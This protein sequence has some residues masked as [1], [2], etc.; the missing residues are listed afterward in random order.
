MP[1]LRVVLLLAAAACIGGLTPL[2]VPACQPLPA[3]LDADAIALSSQFFARSVLHYGTLRSGVA[4][5]VLRGEPLSFLTIGGSVAC[6]NS[7]GR[8]EDTPRGKADAFPAWFAQYL[9]TDLVLPAGQTHSHAVE[10]FGSVHVGSWVMHLAK[11]KE[12][13]ALRE[14]VTR[15]DVVLLDTVRSVRSK[16]MRPGSEATGGSRVV[17]CLSPRHCCTSAAL[18]EEL[19]TLSSCAMLS[20][21][22]TCKLVSLL[23]LVPWRKKGGERRSYE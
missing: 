10:C 20:A 4:G 19:R 11:A 12:G 7:D 22:P 1:G 3:A 14:M 2:P 17:V 15:A 21:A 16:G 5:K 8:T 9:T 18:A 23:L 6:G 13:Q